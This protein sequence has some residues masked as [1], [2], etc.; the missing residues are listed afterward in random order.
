MLSSN[1]SFKL[2]LWVWFFL[3]FFGWLVG[4]FVLFFCLAGWLVWLGYFT[5]VPLKCWENWCAMLPDLHF[6]RVFCFLVT[7]TLQGLW[8]RASF[9]RLYSATHSKTW[10]GLLEDTDQSCKPQQSITVVRAAV[11]VSITFL[12]AKERE[13]PADPSSHMCLL[14][15]L[16]TKQ[17]LLDLEAVSP[18][19]TW[20]LSSNQAAL[21]SSP[22]KE[23]GKALRGR[24]NKNCQNEQG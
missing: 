19:D 14:Q 15:L 23:Q 18:R 6:H 16:L 4:W 10:L 7:P 12:D 9:L 8:S 11:S 5:T 17:C 1:P 21:S 13:T 24:A 2:S 22:E 3:L 20:S